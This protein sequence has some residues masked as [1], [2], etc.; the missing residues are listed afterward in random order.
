MDLVSKRSVNSSII[1]AIAEVR[2]QRRQSHGSNG[3]LLKMA[4]ENVWPSPIT[5][6]DS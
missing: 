5:G 4:G 6:E 1:S 2:I 3:E